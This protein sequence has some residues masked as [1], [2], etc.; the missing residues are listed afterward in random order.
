[1]LELIRQYA[2]E[3]LEHSGEAETVRYW[4]AEHFLALAKR[5]ETEFWGQYEAAWSE[6]LETDHDNLRAALLWTLERDETETSL[7]LAGAL[8]WFWE[9][10]SHASEG[11]RWLE[12]ALA[13]G[14]AATTTARA[15]ALLG[16]GKILKRNEIEQAQAYLEEAL[17]LYEGL[18][19]RVRVADCM[20]LLGW[21]ADYRGDRERASVLYEEGLM[22]ARESEDRRIIGSLLNLLAY[23][24]FEGGAFERAQAL[25]EEALVLHR[26]RGGPG[27]ASGILL[28]MG[29]IELVKG[30][31]GRATALLEETLTLSREAGDEYQVAGSLMCLGIAATLRGEPERA[32][33][34]LK[35]SLAMDVE[36]GGKID[37]AED[38]EGLAETAGALGQPLRAARIWGA[39]G[40]LREEIR[41]PWRPAERMLHESY[42]TAAR[43]RLDGASWEAAFAEGRAMTF[44]E[45]VEY[46][47]HEEDVIQ[48]SAVNGSGASDDQ[49]LVVLTSREREV[50]SLVARGLTN[51]QIS[52]ELG[53]SERTAGNHVAR[54][55]RKLGLRSRTQIAS[56]VSET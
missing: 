13:K 51:R 3:K 47:L 36:L 14:G 6:R 48:A 53:I 2:L 29:Y 15:G 52:T 20:S 55:L 44:E 35:E 54:I 28:N 42:L 31:Q 23:H 7:R 40:M 25:W 33:A 24:A 19:E 5:A 26:E 16:L 37:I 56:W 38:L 45:A 8:S 27:G 1:M 11:A 4:H 12:E 32:E 34:L 50:A 9:E 18:G 41:V 39:A 46:A 43:C 22:A 30:D 21:V 17:A 10:R 49:P